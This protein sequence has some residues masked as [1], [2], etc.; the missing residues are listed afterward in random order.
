V[1]EAMER[2]NVTLSI[3]KE[4]LYKAKLLAVKRRTSVSG[5]LTQALEVLV[6]QEDAYAHAQQRH[7]QW[8]EQGANLG[9]GGQMLTRRDELHEQ[10]L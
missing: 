7:L 3:P 5:L 10:A 2:Q 9:S 6:E 1:E 4:T 8:L